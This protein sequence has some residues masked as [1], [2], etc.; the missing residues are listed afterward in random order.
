MIT[1]GFLIPTERMV[2]TNNGVGFIIFVLCMQVGTTNSVMG[3]SKALTKKDYERGSLATA[4]V[5]SSILF[6]I[7]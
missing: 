7:T 3:L 4:P 2:F 5:F 6:G 1:F